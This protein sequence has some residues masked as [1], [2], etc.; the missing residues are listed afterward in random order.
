[1][2]QQPAFCGSGDQT[3]PWPVNVVAGGS[4]FSGQAHGGGAGGGGG[5]QQA[6]EGDEDKIAF[7]KWKVSKE[8]KKVSDHQS[9]LVRKEKVKKKDERIETQNRNVN[10]LSQILDDLLESLGTDAMGCMK[11]EKARKSLQQYL[12]NKK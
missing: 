1:M 4:G 12:A 10:V 7:Q 9:Y 2:M 8:K 5:V 6:P 11:S 3:P